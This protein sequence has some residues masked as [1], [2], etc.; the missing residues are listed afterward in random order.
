MELYLRR[1]CKYENDSM[2]EK[3]I[4]G[5]VKTSFYFAQ[6]MNNKEI[7]EHRFYTFE[8][9]VEKLKREG[10]KINDQSKLIW[11]LKS[12]NYQNVINWYNKPFLI[13]DS[14]KQYLSCANS[15]M[16]INFFNFNRSI[17]TLLIGDLH[18]IEMQ[19]SSSIT[20][21][22]MKIINQFH[23]GHT[24]FGVLT[25]N[26]KFQLF[27]TKKSTKIKQISEDFQKNFNELKENKDF[28]NSAWQSWEEVPMYSLSL[29]WTFG[30]P[31]HLFQFL[32]K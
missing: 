1:F 31:I 7:V 3:P 16:I 17:S 26:E 18:S 20:Y 29:L 10:L 24:I 27:A 21:E 4:K 28:I 9:L 12:F 30:M 5:G 22:I 13:N 32:N 11:Y 14:Y 8:E 23:P 2:V 19:L 15:Q 25:T 6:N